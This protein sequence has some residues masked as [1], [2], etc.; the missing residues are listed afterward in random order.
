MITFTVTEMRMKVRI[1]KKDYEEQKIWR[2][3][4]SAHKVRVLPNRFGESANTK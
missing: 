1:S 2:E 3:W 4:L